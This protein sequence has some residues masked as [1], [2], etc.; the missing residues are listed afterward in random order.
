MPSGPMTV[1]HVTLNLCDQDIRFPA[2]VG[3]SREHLPVGGEAARRNEISSGARSGSYIRLGAASDRRMP[4]PATTSKILVSGLQA[5]LLLPRRTVRPPHVP[6]GP[7][8]LVMLRNSPQDRLPLAAYCPI[9]SQRFACQPF[10]PHLTHAKILNRR[11]S[12]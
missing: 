1:H 2:P 9:P 11:T 6:A 10:S 3:L 12:T 8:T 4:R 5:G 7:G